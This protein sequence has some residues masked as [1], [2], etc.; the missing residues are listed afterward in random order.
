VA[1]DR[2]G[3]A[4]VPT[5]EVVE[6]AQPVS[7]IARDEQ[8]RFLP[9]RGEGPLDRCTVW[10][11]PRGTVGWG[12]Q[13]LLVPSV[14]LIVRRVCRPAGLWRAAM[15]PR[16]L[17]GKE[18]YATV[19]T[20]WRPRWEIWWD[21]KNGQLHRSAHGLPAFKKHES[22]RKPYR[23]LA[24]D[25][26]ITMLAVFSDG[27][28]PVP[29]PEH[30]D[31]APPRLGRLSRAVPRKQGPDCSGVRAAL[32][33]T[34]VPATRGTFGAFVPKVP[35]AAGGS[36]MMGWLIAFGRVYRSFGA[37]FEPELVEQ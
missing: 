5:T 17:G 15:F 36:R 14:N 10:C 18:A 25:L 23:R 19:W 26:A 31:T 2:V 13:L 8:C 27:R 37:T 34:D 22:T 3:H 28:T 16:F 11:P 35:R 6:S 29:N 4:D 9:D 33:L 32:R 12:W 21:S 20:G 30:Y 24:G 1:E 7:G